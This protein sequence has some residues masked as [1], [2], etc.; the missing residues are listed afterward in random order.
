MIL[1]I[2]VDYLQSVT[3]ERGVSDAEL[4][5]LLM[6]LDG[7]STAEIAG[8][9]G[10]SNIA[11]RKRLG[12]VYRKFNIIGRG[13]GKLAEL[14]HIVLSMYQ[15]GPTQAVFNPPERT[16]T[17]APLSTPP[18]RK[19]LTE[20]PDVSNFYGRSQELAELEQWVLQDSCRLVG[21][22]GLGGNGKTTLSV[23]LAKR[24]E[25]EFDYVIWRSLR[26]A[27][28][29]QDL[30]TQ[31]LQTFSNQKKLDI[32]GDL[33]S[34]ISRLIEYLRKNDSLIVF[35]DFET[36]LKTEELAGQYRKEYEGYREL[37]KRIAEA[38]HNSCLMIISNEKPADLALLQG[39]K[40]RT[41]T[42][43]GSEEVCREIL[44]EKDF[45][46]E[47]AWPTLIQRYGANPLAI[48]IISA[49][50]AE[51]FGGHV[52]EFTKDTTS[53]FADSLS[54]L[55]GEQ[56]ERLSD[57]E[58][59]IMYWLALEGEPMSLAT[60][61]DELVL[62]ISQ[63][64]LLKTFASL[65][66][67]SLIEKTSENSETLFSLQPLIMKYIRGRFIEQ[68]CTEIRELLKTQK[69]D[70][71]QLLRSHDITQGIE[72]KP[73][74]IPPV[75]KAI[76]DKLLQS[77]MFN[78]PTFLEE[79]LNTLNQISSKLD[80]KSRLEIQYADENLNSIVTALKEDI[81]S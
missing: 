26:N 7:Q 9:L 38:N 23:Q 60:F 27:P 16:T 17:T 69:L 11:V 47:K 45:T 24:S 18:R 51:V 55:L 57:S 5:A 34:R 74:N 35:D 29:I 8:Q 33:N 46:G 67:R 19:D 28:P 39:D 62:P 32:P 68:I 50:I 42:L 71:I 21:V 22:L 10:I 53:Y 6:A 61:R 13:P 70:N 3:S 56:F 75:L 65:D 52:T 20:A 81:N 49:T 31:L 43:G 66:R 78:N 54:D 15:G 80:G 30:L 14:R 63:S 73:K 64:E 40:V 41:L 44:K 4:E 36:I 77:K 76:K 58:A 2:P 72:V 12:E 48:K 37:L 79:M 25:D 1:Q 59:D